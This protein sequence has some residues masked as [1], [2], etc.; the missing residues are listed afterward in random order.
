MC[1]V[2]GALKSPTSERNLNHN[3]QQPFSISICVWYIQLSHGFI[4]L[5]H[6][7]YVIYIQLSHGLYVIYIQLSHDLYVIYI[8]LPHDL[9][10]IYIQLS[11]GFISKLKLNCSIATVAIL[12]C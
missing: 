9:Y 5:S 10:V 6:G 12:A 7:L 2:T 4:Q 11:H 3:V 1:S 8:Q